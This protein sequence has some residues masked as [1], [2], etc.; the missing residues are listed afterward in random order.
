MHNGMTNALQSASGDYLHHSYPYQMV[1]RV[2]AQLH[3]SGEQSDLV[4]VNCGDMLKLAQGDVTSQT[5]VMH[6]KNT[7]ERIRFQGGF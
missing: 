6:I 7:L 4:E 2:S 1:G 3:I 5:V